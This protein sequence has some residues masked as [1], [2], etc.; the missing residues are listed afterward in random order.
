MW[1]DRYKVF[2]RFVLAWS[3]WLITETAFTYF[4]NMGKIDTP[5]AVVITGV[6]GILTVVIGFQKDDSNN[7]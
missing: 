5:D 6:I 2:R 3:C 1:L 7:R 4:G